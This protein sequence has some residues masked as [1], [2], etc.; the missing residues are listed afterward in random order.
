M[1]KVQ[2][3]IRFREQMKELLSLAQVGDSNRMLSLEISVELFPIL[4]STVLLDLSK[5]PFFSITT[6]NLNIFK[7]L[8][9]TTK[10]NFYN[11][12]GFSNTISLIY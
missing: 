8:T 11:K 7:L 5:L 9:S 4:H 12:R 2:V 10:P 1:S 3:P 6:H